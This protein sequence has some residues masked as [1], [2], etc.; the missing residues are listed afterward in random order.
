MLKFIPISLT[1]AVACCSPSGFPEG[2]WAMA[3]GRTPRA[4]EVLSQWCVCFQTPHLSS[5][6]EHVSHCRLITRPV[7]AEAKEQGVGLLVLKLS[8][9]GPVLK[10]LE[11]KSLLQVSEFALDLL[12]LFKP[13][14]RLFHPSNL[15]K[16]TLLPP[17]LSFFLF[18]FFPQASCSPY[19]FAMRKKLN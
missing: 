12:S 6:R 4:R 2:C 1:M 14:D 10:F 18:S 16:T 13:S 11:M 15:Y 9:P 7:Y 8:S 3:P 5:E 17:S 19:S